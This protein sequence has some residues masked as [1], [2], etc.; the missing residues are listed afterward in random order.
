MGSSDGPHREALEELWATAAE[1]VRGRRGGH[2][3]LDDLAEL[4]RV[5][6]ASS[7]LEQVDYLAFL[8]ATPAGFL[9]AAWVPGTGR[10]RIEALFVV[11][12]LRGVGVGHEL[13]DSLV[14]ELRRHRCDRLDAV[15]LPGDRATKNF[16][17]AHGMV[18]RAL[19][20]H[21]RLDDGDR[22]W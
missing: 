18:T 9:R 20:V 14:G 3:L 11:P 15:A 6:S 17:E 5:G 22:P 1:W 12:E 13:L 21:T 4:A 7:E 19:V 10:A 16:F 8:G 2:D